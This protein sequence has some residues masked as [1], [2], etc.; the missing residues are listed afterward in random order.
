MPPG[1]QRPHPLYAMPGAGRRGGLPGARYPV[2]GNGLSRSRSYQR[3]APSP[4]PWTGY[5]LASISPAQP[6]SSV[7]QLSCWSRT[8]ISRYRTAQ[9]SASLWR[10]GTSTTA[11][12]GC[13]ASR[14]SQPRPVARVPAFAAVR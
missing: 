11:A 14:P 3:G 8:S 5:S 2:P 10:V 4:E 9:S 12:V 6:A 1:R 13:S 7:D